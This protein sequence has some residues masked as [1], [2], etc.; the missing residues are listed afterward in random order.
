[1][2]ASKPTFFALPIRS[3]IAS[4][5][6]FGGTVC[7]TLLLAATF[8]LGT[9][10][11][12]EKTK[13]G[14]VY[15]GPIGDHGWTHA[16]DVGRRAL[17]EEFGSGV[18]TTFLES[19][20]EGA[21]AEGAI[22]RLANEGHD[23]IFTTSFGYM[24]PTLK[25]AREFPDIRFEHATGYKR[26][27]NVSTYSIRFYEGRY[28]QGV[29]AG[30]MTQSN[31][32]GYVAAFPIPEVMRGINAFLLGA[33]SVNPEVTL[34]LVWVNTWFDPGKERDAA[35]SLIDRGADIIA[36]HT[37][38]A[39]PLQVASENGVFAFG[40][41]SDMR[42]FAPRAQ[43]SAS[44]NS[45]GPYYVARV[46]AAK[47]G[48]WESQDTWGGLKSGMLTM[49]EYANMPDE[50]KAAARA[51]EQGIRDGSVA[52]WKG[53][54]VDTDGTEHLAAGLELSDQA[55]LGMAWALEGV[56]GAP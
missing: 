49:A 13:V 12:Q 9:A 15:V 31:A 6:A 33:R 48:S 38:S 29:I 55:L 42:A 52:I 27:D 39:A 54:L 22:R 23:V 50:V 28:I 51:A 11:A 14:F 30:H 10:A 45:W 18:E 21:D 46:Q 5:V 17:E 24:N 36:Q 26:S 4:A 53:P 40:Q 44:V 20:P 8:V 34:H 43:L 1:M 3:F 2:S 37:D 56:Q 41:A 7:A 32:I 19:V 16:H 47:D 25:V 35:Q